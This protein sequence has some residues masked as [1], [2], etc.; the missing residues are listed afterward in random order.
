MNDRMIASTW[1]VASP[2][3]W[4]RALAVGEIHVWLTGLDRPSRSLTDLA[5]TLAVNERERAA[6]F[7]F[8]EHRDRFVAGRGLLRQL[9]GAYLGRPATSLRFE[10]GSHGKPALAG[11][12]AEAG[13]H[14]NLSH[15]GDGALYA[16]AYQEVGVDLERL[17]RTAS[18]AA[19]LDRVCT[20][21]ERALF[22]M[23]PPG[24]EREA[25]FSCWTRKEAIAKALGGGLASGLQNLEVCFGDDAHP[26]GRACLHDATQRQ[27][28]VLNLPLE[29]GW[30]GA[31]AAAGADWR[32]RGWRLRDHFFDLNAR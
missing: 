26:D 31:L 18:F 5:A 21:C 4:G 25:F 19:I 13:L 15:S 27:W 22:R 24:R 23:L 16:I 30:S 2:N 1:P 28:S 29:F 7:R 8:P 32:W 17:D 6:R 9:L 10:Q 12:E 20:P 14:F 11:I 3:E